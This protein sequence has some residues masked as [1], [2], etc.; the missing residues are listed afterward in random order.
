MNIGSY[1][2]EKE[3]FSQVNYHKRER[4]RRLNISGNRELVNTTSPQY[5]YARTSPL[6]GSSNDL[7]DDLQDTSSVY[8]EVEHHYQCPDS[9]T[10]VDT[11]D[12]DPSSPRFKLK[13]IDATSPKYD[14][15]VAM[16]R[17]ICYGSS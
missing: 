9:E 5:D 12:L 2:D 6:I 13:K 16:Q 7:L 4:P 8:N 15:P 3:S 11:E 17:N 1:I 14:D 10:S